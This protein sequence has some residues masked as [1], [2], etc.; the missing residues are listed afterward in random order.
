MVAITVRNVPNQVR[1]ELAAQ[2]ASA[3]TSLEAYLRQVLRE[4]AEKPPINEWLRRVRERV[5]ESGRAI[6]LSDLRAA[7]DA[8]RDDAGR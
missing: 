5:N 4:T 8:D 3:G 2:A 1:D 7:I 6:P